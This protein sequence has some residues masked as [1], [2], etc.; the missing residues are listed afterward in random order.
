MGALHQGPVIDNCTGTGRVLQQQAEIAVQGLALQRRL[1]TDD[2][3]DTQWP[4]T[5]K[6]HIEG[7]RVAIAGSEERRGF[8]LRQAL[9]EGHGL[10]GSGGFIEQRGVG[11]FHTGQVADQGLEVQQ[12]FQAALG[13]FR[14][15]RG[16]RGVPGRVLQQVAQD[17]GRRMARVIALADVVAIQLVVRGNRL[18]AAS[19]SAS[20]CPG[21]SESTLL[22]FILAGMT[23]STS[24]S[25]DSWPVSASMA[26]CRLR[27]GQCDGRQIHQACPAGYRGCSWR[28]P[29]FRRCRPGSARSRPGPSG[30][31]GQQGC[32]PGYGRTSRPASARR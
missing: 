12:C 9:A 19:A 13:N 18:S 1:I 30:Y 2:H 31:R 23:L 8:V 20:P 29:Q 11:D 7:L 26:R 24:A 25:S 27:A 10:G 6:Q 32:W 16:V 3:L 15:V 4:R 17:R 5:G 21:V 22:P 14:L 28:P